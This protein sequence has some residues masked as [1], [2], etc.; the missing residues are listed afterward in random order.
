MIEDEGFPRGSAGVGV[1]E[2][3][4]ADKGTIEPEASGEEIVLA[5]GVL[6]G[7]DPVEDGTEV[8]SRG[9]GVFEDEGVP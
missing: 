8:G 9:D 1:F 5:L 3:K 7:V 6:E 4:G 2:P